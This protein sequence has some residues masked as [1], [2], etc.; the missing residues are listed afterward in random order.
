MAVPWELECLM[1]LR[2]ALMPLLAQSQIIGMIVLAQF[3]TSMWTTHEVQRL[4]LDRMFLY[5][6]LFAAVNFAVVFVGDQLARNHGWWSRQAYLLIGA[7]GATAAHAVALAPGGYFEAARSGVILLILAIPALLGA[8]TGFLMHRSLGYSTG[9]DDPHALAEMA[10]DTRA[11]PVAADAVH[12][13]GTSQ[14]YEGPLQ[15]RTSGMAAF[16][17]ALVASSLYSLT[18]MFSLSDGLLPPEAMPPLYRE[19]PAL[20]ALVGIGFYSLFFYLFIRKAHGFLQAR[21]KDQ[22]RSYALAGVVVPMGFALMLLA[23]MGPFGIMIVLPWIVPSIVAMISYHRL[24][25]FEPLA[26]PSDI[27]VADPRAMI[28]ADHIRRRVRRVIPVS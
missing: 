5:F 14:Y 8:A 25:G 1:K 27:E 7:A 15:V 18:V 13:V 26:L 9:G 12:D 23:L 3:Q 6:L 19:N 21:G 17:A 20:M 22:M 16:V 11:E 4:T 24:A 28:S 10:E 2:F